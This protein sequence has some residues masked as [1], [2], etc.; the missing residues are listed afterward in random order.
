MWESSIIGQ[1]II[2]ISTA[3]GFWY[4]DYSKRRDREWD[5]KDREVNRKVL[6]DKVEE[7]RQTSIYSHDIVVKKLDENTDM[8]R[9]AI[10]E[11]NNF[12]QKLMALETFLSRPFDRKSMGIQQRENDI[13]EASQ[14]KAIIENTAAVVDNTR[15]IS[16]DTNAVV[17]NIDEKLLRS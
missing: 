1:L 14:L 4:Q 6:S 16:A 2:L 7:V 9:V 13:A 5:L 12:N 15:I 17:H 10:K 11:S 8:T 3:L